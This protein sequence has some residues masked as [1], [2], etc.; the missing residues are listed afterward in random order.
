MNELR[1]INTDA[2]GLPID[3]RHNERAGIL[4]TVLFLEQVARWD[5]SND[6]RKQARAQ[7]DFLRALIRRRSRDGRDTLDGA[8]REAIERLLAPP[9]KQLA[10]PVRQIPPPDEVI[11]A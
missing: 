10:A 5:T 11:D 3:W 2:D 8:L 7:A 9:P 4:G 1:E 6:F